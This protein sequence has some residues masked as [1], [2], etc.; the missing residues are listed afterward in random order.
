MAQQEE[1]TAAK[2][3]ILSSITG[4]QR[5]LTPAHCALTSKYIHTHI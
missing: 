5:E 3:D 2:S 4:T 1:E